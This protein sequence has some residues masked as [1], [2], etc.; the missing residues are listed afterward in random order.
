MSVDIDSG[1]WFIGVALLVIAFW[2]EPDLID[3]LIYFLMN[4]FWI[5]L[6]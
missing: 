1:S 3:A 6:I 2:N 4:K 5:L